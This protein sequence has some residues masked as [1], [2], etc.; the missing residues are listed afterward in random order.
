MEYYGSQMDLRSRLDAEMTEKA[1]AELASSVL[2]PEERIVFHTDNLVLFDQAVTRCLQHNHAEAGAVP[3]TVREAEERTGYLC[4]PSGT[5]HR[6]LRLQGDWYKKSFGTKFILLPNPMYGD[7]ENNLA[8]K[9][10]KLPAG[11]RIAL[12]KA[13]MKS[14][15]YKEK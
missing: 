11:Q 1:F 10:R 13:A 12:R 9:Y 6:A 14:F 7:W 5:M 8:Q 4:R 2:P 3:D 15:A